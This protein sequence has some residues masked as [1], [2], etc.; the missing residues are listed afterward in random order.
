MAR[1]GNNRNTFGIVNWYP[2]L[3]NLVFYSKVKDVNN[4]T[5]QYYFNTFTLKR[6]SMSTKIIYNKAEKKNPKPK[7]LSLAVG[8]KTVA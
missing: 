7:F 1:M 2:E 3:K 4:L 8:R 5:L 6:L